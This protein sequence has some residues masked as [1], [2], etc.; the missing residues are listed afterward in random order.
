MRLRPA[1]THLRLPVLLPGCC[2]LWTQL[3]LVWLTVSGSYLRLP[4]RPAP[5]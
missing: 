5:V 4:G 1:T 2:L 3:T